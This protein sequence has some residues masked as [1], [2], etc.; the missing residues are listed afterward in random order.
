MPLEAGKDGQ[1]TLAVTAAAAAAAARSARV[2]EW[3]PPA[4]GGRGAR[5][6]RVVPTGSLVPTAARNGACWPATR[7]VQPPTALHSTAHK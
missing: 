2:T 6:D 5:L 4:A 7:A 3:A 1:S